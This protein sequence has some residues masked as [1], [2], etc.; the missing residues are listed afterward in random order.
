MSGS[1]RSGTGPAQDRPRW[2]R[3]VPL[4]EAHLIALGAGGL[5]AAIAPLR[6]PIGRRAAAAAGWPVLAAAVAFGSWAVASSTRAG[7]TVDRTD[8]LVRRGAF[9][10]SRNPM[11]LAWSF[12]LLG[13]ATLTRSVWLLL[14]AAAAAT[15][16]HREV[17][18]EEVALERAFGDE[19]RDYRATTRRYL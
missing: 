11:Y 10:V 9:G 2:W 19:Y 14:G 3:N 16:V 5:L 8:G 6:I 18:R 17:L 4:P 1:E 12:A 7:V 13:L 15:A